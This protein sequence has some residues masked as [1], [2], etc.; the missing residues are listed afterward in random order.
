MD[1]NE[2]DKVIAKLALFGGKLGWSSEQPLRP[3]SLH[4]LEVCFRDRFCTSLCAIGS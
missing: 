1:P 3:G 2:S 4:S